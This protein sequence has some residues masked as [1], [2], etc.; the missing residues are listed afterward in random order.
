M[1]DAQERS[2][3]VPVLLAAQRSINTLLSLD[4]LSEKSVQK[5]RAWSVKRECYLASRSPR[6]V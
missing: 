1:I 2:L 3:Q 4:N 6:N 5:V